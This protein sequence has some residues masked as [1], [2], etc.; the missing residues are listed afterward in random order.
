MCNEFCWFDRIWC[1]ESISGL[2]FLHPVWRPIWILL[3]E[4]LKRLFFTSDWWDSLTLLAKLWIE[5]NL[6]SE[7]MC[8]SSVKFSH[9]KWLVQFHGGWNTLKFHPSVNISFMWFDR[10]TG[11]WMTDC[12]SIDQSKSTRTLP[13]NFDYYLIAT[14]SCIEYL[15]PFLRI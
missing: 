10:M 8:S 6:S 7:I 13:T 2:Q 15:I 1:N 3:A 5:L 11:G 14:K 9:S 12:N 4:I